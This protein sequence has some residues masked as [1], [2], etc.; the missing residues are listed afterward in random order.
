M[1]H[2]ARPRVPSN[3]VTK[4][5]LKDG[6]EALLVGDL[7]LRGGPDGIDLATDGSGGVIDT[8]FT[9]QTG[10]ASVRIEISCG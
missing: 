2:I 8:E 3:S 9:G 4:G 6:T 10:T 5:R 1:S 7:F